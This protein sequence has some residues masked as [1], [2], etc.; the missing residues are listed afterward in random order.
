MGIV[1]EVEIEGKR[2]EALFDT[3]SFHTYVARPLL[4]GVPI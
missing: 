3:G 4:E 1:K 2:A